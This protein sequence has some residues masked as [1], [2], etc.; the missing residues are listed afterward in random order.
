MRSMVFLGYAKVSL[1]FLPILTKHKP[2]FVASAF[3]ILLRSLR[4]AQGKAGQVRSGQ[5][6]GLKETPEAGFGAKYIWIPYPLPT[7]CWGRQVRNDNVTSPFPSSFRY[8]VVNRRRLNKTPNI[9]TPA[10][11][12]RANRG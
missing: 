1:L 7:N 8:A 3:A 11:S 6:W 2:I 5:G 4:Q 12:S 10:A 9:K